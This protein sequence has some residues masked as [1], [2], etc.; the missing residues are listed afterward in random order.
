MKKN[1]F[2]AIMALLMVFG[3]SK[4]QWTDTELESAT[5]ENGMIASKGK[6]G[7][8]PGNGV[9]LISFESNSTGTADF[10]TNCLPEGRNLLRKGAFSGSLAGFGKIKSSLSTYEI[11]SCE[12]LAINPPNAG[13]PLMY[14]IVA[15]G[16]LATGPNDYCSI[17]FTGNIYPF[18]DSER[19][20]D[21][22]TFIGSAKAFSGV[23]K[24]KG[25]DNKSFEVYNGLMESRSG[26]NLQTG[27]IRLWFSDYGQ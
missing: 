10:V 17:T 4:D 26:I 21:S 1:H 12:A 11:V 16:K 14:S 20:F 6:G 2:L 22:G 19:G 7:T 8:K 13:E 15:E 25:L 3:C 24:L 23:G 18:Y 5:S 9:N 27:N